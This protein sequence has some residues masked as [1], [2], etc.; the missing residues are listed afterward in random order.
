MGILADNF[1]EPS[2]QTSSSEVQLAISE[3]GLPK[4]SEEKIVL[5]PLQDDV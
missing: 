5:D 3:E 4:K 1:C 2:R